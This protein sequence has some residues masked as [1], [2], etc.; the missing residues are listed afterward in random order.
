MFTLILTFVIS[1]LVIMLV[2][3]ICYLVS[4]GMV[5]NKIY[6]DYLEWH[7][8]TNEQRFDVL[9]MCSTCRFCGKR[10]LQDSQGNWF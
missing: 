1:L 7:I 4:D 2:T 9:S 8:P 6:H 3:A 10:I 5:F